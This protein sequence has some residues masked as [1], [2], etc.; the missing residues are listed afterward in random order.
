LDAVCA[1]PKGPCFRLGWHQLRAQ[2]D[3]LLAVLDADAGKREHGGSGG[4][5]RCRSLSW[6]TAWRNGAAWS[7]NQPRMG[8]RCCSGWLTGRV[9][10]TPR[11]DGQGYDF[12]ASTRFDQLSTG[13]LAPRPSWVHGG[14]TWDGTTAGYSRV[15]ARRFQDN[16]KRGGTPALGQCPAWVSR[17]GW[18]L[19]DRQRGRS[20]AGVLVPALLRQGIQA[21]GHV[22]TIGMQSM[23]SGTT[24]R[25]WSSRTAS[26]GSAF[27]GCVWVAARKL[28]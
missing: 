16:W 10:F 23:I 4:P 6:R 1:S 20:A 3:S 22:F 18:W 14:L 9:T 26:M 12:S 13:V 15:L 24:S 25:S 8:E 7:G 28:W 5:P 21:V 27:K 2:L 17:P 11:A 19:V